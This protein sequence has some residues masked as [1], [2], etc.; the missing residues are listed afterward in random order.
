MTGLQA[1]R[2]DRVRGRCVVAFTMVAPIVRYLVGAAAGQRREPLRPVCAVA[3]SSARRRPRRFR[4][5]YAGCRNS[6]GTHVVMSLSFNV[7]VAL[8]VAWLVLVA[9]C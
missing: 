5:T 4:A 7:G 1:R 2:S 9:A 8:L 3:G 6:A